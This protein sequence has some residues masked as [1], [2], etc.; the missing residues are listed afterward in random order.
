MYEGLDKR[1][2]QNFK[3]CHNR[4]RD[5]KVKEIEWA[6]D[7]DGYISFL[8]E[9]GLKPDDDQKWSVGRIDHSRGYVS[10]NIQWELH[11]HNSVKRRGTKYQN[12]KDAEPD[13]IDLSPSFKKGSKEWLQHQKQASN[14]RW[15]DPIQ[16]EKARIRMLGN[17]HGFK[18][19][20]QEIENGERNIS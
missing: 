1:S 14:K 6:R 10:G 8:K 16:K 18:R 2:L 12:V 5:G 9:I 7:R 19:K 13:L 3:C 17:T 4:V 15:S 20:L 11:K